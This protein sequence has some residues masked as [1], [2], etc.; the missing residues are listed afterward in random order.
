M[1]DI[2]F[3][4]QSAKIWAPSFKQIPIL[5]TGLQSW[6][7]CAADDPSTSILIWKNILR[8]LSPLFCHQN[9]KIKTVIGNK[10]SPLK[11]LVLCKTKPSEK[12]WGLNYKPLEQ[13]LFP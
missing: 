4:L 6:Q 12:F 13:R 3:L 1:Q 7:L 2:L 8:W 9:R 10:T 11:K 5:K